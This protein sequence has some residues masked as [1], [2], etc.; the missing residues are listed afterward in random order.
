MSKDPVVS[1][2]EAIKTGAPYVVTKKDTARPLGASKKG[3]R[4]NMCGYRLQPGDSMWF[5]WGTYRGGPGP[6]AVFCAKCH[7]PDDRTKWAEHAK[8][9]REQYWW[10]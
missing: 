5:V 7:G 4:C 8:R 1:L 9:G 6:N 3:P 10:M 2:G